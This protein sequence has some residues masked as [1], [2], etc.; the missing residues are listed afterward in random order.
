ML[1]IYVNFIKDEKLDLEIFK[2]NYRFLMK[3]LNFMRS[4]YIWFGSIIFF[5]IFVIGMKFDIRKDSFK[6]KNIYFN[7]KVN[8]E[9]I[10]KCRR[11]Y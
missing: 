4:V 7:K 11:S 3:I 1:Y 10:K 5:P 8:Y 6:I 2:K 9:A